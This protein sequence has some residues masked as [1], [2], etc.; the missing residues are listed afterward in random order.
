LKNHLI[1]KI[2]PSIFTL[3]NLLCGFLAVINI[4]EGTVSSYITAAWWIIIAGIFD[5]LDGKIARITDSSSEFGIEFDSIAD[6][7]SFGIA[8]AVLFYSY[9]LNEAGKLGYVIAFCFLATGAIRLAR[10]NTAAT[11][12]KKDHFT[13]M[14]IPAGAGIIVSFILFSENVWGGLANFDFAVALVLLT[15]LAMVSNFKYSVF[16]KIGFGSKRDR[17][18]SIWFIIHILVIIR[19]PD[20]VFFPTGILY[21]LSG[22]TKWLTVPAVNHVLGKVTAG[23]NQPV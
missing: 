13:G 22:P 14:P 16:P 10:F 11:T 4:I 2:L 18:K 23:K 3:G 6:V 15:S 19:F 8:P 21:L 12:Q 7:V 20:E 17:I 1:K 9:I 5:A